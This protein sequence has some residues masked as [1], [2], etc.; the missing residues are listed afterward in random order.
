MRAGTAGANVRP[1]D[2]TDEDMLRREV[3]EEG[4]RT[5]EE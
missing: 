4:E 1:Y 2:S 3:V 5:K